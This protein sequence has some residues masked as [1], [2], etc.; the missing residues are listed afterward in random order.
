[1]RLPDFIIIGAAKAGTTSLHAILKQHPDIF[2]PAQKEPE[3]FARDDRFAAGV[4]QYATHFKQARANQL[5]GEASTIY[6]L[7]PLFPDTARRMA[8]TLPDARIIYVLREPVSRAFSYYAQLIKGYQNA[9][10]DLAVHRCFE[11][12]VLPERHAVAA[13][14]EKVLSRHNSHLPDVPELCLAG[15]DYVH[16]VETYLKVYPREQ[17]LFLLF[18]D[19]ITDRTAFVRQITDF[20][21]VAPINR[22]ALASASAARNVAQTHFR[23]VSV[24][25]EASML[26]ARLAGL[27]WLRKALPRSGRDFLKTSLLSGRKGDA[28][29]RP[30]PMQAETRLLLQERFSSQYHRLS[31]L[32]GLDLSAWTERTDTTL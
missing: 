12:F 13:P 19:F 25:K 18:E 14:T 32:T 29:V 8:E 22:S 3:F 1:M 6:S 26:R 24:E 10:R 21:G 17:M 23:V 7:A 5:V 30:R 11:D 2:M 9:T 20:L 27:W 31:E 16:Q 4:A 28:L 15:S